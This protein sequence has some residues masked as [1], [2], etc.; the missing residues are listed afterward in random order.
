MFQIIEKLEQII[1]TFS[2]SYNSPSVIVSEDK[3]CSN[4]SRQSNGRQLLQELVLQIRFPV[5]NLA[6][7]LQSAITSFF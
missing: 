1:S 7:C 5:E 2:F 3:H 6:M 4:V